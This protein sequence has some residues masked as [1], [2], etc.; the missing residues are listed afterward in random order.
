MDG[1]L[2]VKAATSHLP[3]LK[4]WLSGHSM[5]AARERD[6]IAQECLVAAWKQGEV[7]H[8]PEHEILQRAWLWAVAQRGI[9]RRLRA[10]RRRAEDLVDE[11]ELDACGA[12]ESVDELYRE[13]ERA[14]QVR[15]ALDELAAQ[16]PQL[17]RATVLRWFDELGVKEIAQACAVPENTVWTRLRLGRLRLSEILARRAAVELGHLERTYAR[18]PRCST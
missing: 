11:G 13:V 8:F 9:H 4:T 2:A 12:V 18:R 7:G 5:F 3:T 16:E 14:S 6:D 15:A 1:R 17:H 10:E